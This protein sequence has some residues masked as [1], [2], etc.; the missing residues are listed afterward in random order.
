MV[1]PSGPLEAVLS[2]IAT[3]GTAKAWFVRAAVVG[4]WIGYLL[5]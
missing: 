5:D 3:S 1:C 2:V 4:R